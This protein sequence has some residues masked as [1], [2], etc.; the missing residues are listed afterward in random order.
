MVAADGG[1]LYEPPPIKPYYNQGE[2]W[3]SGIALIPKGVR[4]GLLPTFHVEGEFVVQPFQPYTAF[5]FFF[6][7]F[8][9][10]PGEHFF[11]ILLP[12]SY[13]NFY[14]VNRLHCALTAAA[15][16]IQVMARN[17]TQILVHPMIVV[18]VKSRRIVAVP[19]IIGNVKER[20]DGMQQRRCM[21]E[22]LG[23]E[24]IRRVAIRII[25]VSLRSAL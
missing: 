15:I 20:R 22:W 3:W 10:L 6:P 19:V 25:S 16:R 9:H 5:L 2:N 14:H 11:Q 4:Q 21:V 17:H 18:M 13:V 8:K 1:N 7:L 23:Q 12:V 24:R